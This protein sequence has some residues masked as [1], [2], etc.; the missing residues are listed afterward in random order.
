MRGTGRP[1]D[2]AAPW[3][4]WSFFRSKSNL[5][6]T[7]IALVCVGALVAFVCLPSITEYIEEDLALALRVLRDLLRLI[8]LVFLCKRHLPPCF[9]SLPHTADSRASAAVQLGHGACAT[10]GRNS[11]KSR[12]LVL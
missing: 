6:D 8:R 9:S 7:G 3:R 2:V 5:L 11:A 10:R 12:G 1:P 4:S